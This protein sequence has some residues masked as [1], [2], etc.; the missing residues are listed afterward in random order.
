MSGRECSVTDCDRVHYATGLCSMHYQRVF[1]HGTVDLMTRRTSADW[2][3]NAMKSANELDCIDWP[4]GTT[5]GYGVARVNGRN[6]GAHRLSCTLAHGKP[7]SPELEAA[8][9]C[10]RRLCVNPHHLRW[11]TAV[12]N[13]ADR[14]AHGTHN[15]GERQGRSK[16]TE[17]DVNEIRR[18]SVDGVPQRVLAGR[19]G[20]S[21][22][23]ISDV[24]R[25][26]SWGWLA[27]AS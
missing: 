10:G 26:H 1:H 4:F 3:M 12:G 19:F 18:L 20:V 15:R 21:Q 13:Q 27:N 9:N 5:N 14:L 8:H 24:K 2:L 7:A 16:L 6:I 11:D 23:T 17:S 25:R 22:V